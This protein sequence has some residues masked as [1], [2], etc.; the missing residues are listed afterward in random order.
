MATG[1][2]PKNGSVPY[3]NYT[4]ASDAIR[5]RCRRVEKICNEFGVPLIAAALQ[6]PLLCSAVVSVIPGRTNMYP[7]FLCIRIC[8]HVCI[9]TLFFVVVFFLDV[10]QVVKMNGKSIQM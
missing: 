9:H 10:P 4:E 6:F 1:A 2:D 5:A 8:L 7:S 3:Y